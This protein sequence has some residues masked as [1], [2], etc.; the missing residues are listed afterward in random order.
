MKAEARSQEPGARKVWVER[1][2]FSR[3]HDDAYSN[4][5]AELVSAQTCAMSR[6]A[7]TS[8]SPL[9]MLE[10]ILSEAKNLGCA[11]SGCYRLASRRS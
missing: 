9:R 6:R 10:V 1:V 11:H 3:Q 4:V 7:E 8:L 5:V 2:G